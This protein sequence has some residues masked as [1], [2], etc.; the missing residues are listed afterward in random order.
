VVEDRAPP[1]HAQAWYSVTAVR[2]RAERV[3]LRRHRSP[4]ARARFARG[5]GRPERGPPLLAA[6]RA[7][8]KPLP[9]QGGHHQREG[10]EHSEGEEVSEHGG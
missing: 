2:P 7:L 1:P 5:R 8:R 10:V 9:C 4:P 3:L 6:R